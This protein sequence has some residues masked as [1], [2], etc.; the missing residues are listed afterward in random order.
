MLSSYFLTAYRA[1]RNRPTVTAINVV[2]LAVGL[3]A[4]VLIALWVKQQVS[5][6]T[7]H[8]QADQLYRLALDAS[9]PRGDMTAPLSPAPAAPVLMRDVPGIESATRI[10]EVDQPTI[11]LGNQTFVEDR[12]LSADSLFFDVLSGFQLLQGTP[13][14][15]LATPASAVLTESAAR[16]Y[17]GTTDALGQT[18][19]VNDEQRTVTGIL[20][21]PPVASHI[22]FD[23][24]TTLQLSPE[25]ETSWLANSTYT[26]VRLRG[27]ARPEAFRDQVAEVSDQYVGPQAMELLG[28][29]R[30][31]FEEQSGITYF[32][33]KVTQIHLHS[34]MQYELGPTGS[35]AYVWTF[36]AVAFLILLLACINFTNLATARATERAA[37]V[38]MRKAL[39]AHRGQLA[40]QFLGEAMLTTLV[41]AGLAFVLVQGGLPFFNAIAETNVQLGAV[42]APSVLAVLGGI[43]GVG[44]LAGL[45]PALALSGFTPARVLKGTQRSTTGKG[46]WL[47][48]GLVVF[49]FT[50]T[51]AMM[52]GTAIIWS[53]FDY[54]QS[55]RLGIETERVIAINRAAQLG[56]RQE[57]LKAELQ[58]LPSIASVGASNALFDAGN[59][60]V[61]NFNWVPNDLPSQE[62]TTAATI[63]VDA[64]VAD[65]LGI[66]LNEGRLF[67]P[68]RA[69]DTLAVVI[70]ETAAQMYGFDRPTE[71]TLRTVGPQGETFDVIGVVEDFHFQSL[72]QP[73][74]PVILT[75]DAAP[76]KVLVRAKPGQAEAALAGIQ[77]TWA[78]FAPNLPLTYGFADTQYAQLH[79]DTQRTGRLFLVF[80]G[81][82]IAVACFGL[83]GLAMYTAQR[84][85]K[86]IGIRKA[87]GATTSQIIL[88]LSN[89]FAQLV[90]V[91][92]V[93]AAPIAYLGMS[94]WLSDFA[95]RVDPSAGAF[96]GAGVVAMVVALGTVSIHA[97][98][99]ARLDPATTLRDE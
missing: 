83:F 40:G 49:Q 98:R 58:S 13:S 34:N 60:G 86:E 69:T 31:E 53:Q 84:R 47:R 59:R 1:L 87:L 93:L 78:T 45:Y 41:A 20:A 70:N 42:T 9:G 85:T 39:G 17:F 21:D 76:R 54:I 19:R 48:Q 77:Q 30:Q 50:I 18:I 16:R 71:N 79:Q 27:D 11:Q 8:P 65:V 35:I 52:A 25:V 43:A 97:F 38:G 72:R 80:A 28:M 33:Q 74:R 46:G 99:A 63:S 56:D 73:I 22:Q 32:A 90:G 14:Q 57:T 29:T 12:V 24:L 44:G 2:G 3:A 23:V 96:L 6:D 94:H 95:Y 15:A 10:D 89:R 5:Y 88:L 37:E 51:I 68:A 4:C 26:Y 36:S 62:G 91:A 75:L 81:L 67:D 61:N 92:F 7:F 82:A 55:K 64:N 66:A